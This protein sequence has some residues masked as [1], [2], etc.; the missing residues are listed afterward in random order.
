[1][2]TPAPRP[3]SRPTAD[4]CVHCGEDTSF[5][6][7]R[8]VNRV[9]ADTGERNGYACAEC[10]S[11]ECDRCGEL[12]FEYQTHDGEILCLGCATS[13]GLDDEDEA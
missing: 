8:F 6:S 2:T 7:G 1:M 11:V 10:L 13:A 9:P 12:S 4:P 5:G 3:Q